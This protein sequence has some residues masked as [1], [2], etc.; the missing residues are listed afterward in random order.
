MIGWLQLL[1]TLTPLSLR[2]RVRPIHIFY[3]VI[4]VY[5]YLKNI[6]FRLSRSGRTTYKLDIVI[7]VVQIPYPLIFPVFM[8]IS[9]TCI[10]ILVQIYQI[11]LKSNGDTNTKQ[12]YLVVHIFQQ[13]LTIRRIRSTLLDDWDRSVILL[14]KWSKLSDK[15]SYVGHLEKPCGKIAYL[16]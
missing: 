15:K 1:E 5:A 13:I 9:F 12:I 7:F 11:I 4:C 2:V 3:S 10:N 14:K 8:F 6:I 16:V